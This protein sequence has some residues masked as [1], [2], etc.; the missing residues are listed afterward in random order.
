MKVKKKVKRYF[1][2]LWSALRNRPILLTFDEMREQEKQRKEWC[3]EL[4]IDPND[5]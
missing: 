5:W 2:R 4:G 1:R 3:K